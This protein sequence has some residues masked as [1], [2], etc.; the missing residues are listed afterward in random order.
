M[1]RVEFIT[2][3]SKR[4]LLIDF[5]NLKVEEVL[6]VIA[7][8]KKVMEQQPK[9]SVITLTDLTH[10]S[11]NPEVA[12]A[13][14]EYTV[15]NKPYVKVAAVVGATGLMGVVK[16]GVEKTSMRDLVNFATRE[17]AQ[18]WLIGQN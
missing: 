5:S 18:E 8:A 13:M 10:M 12:S 4:I 9:G 16:D 14:K 2:Y 11:F 7:E 3:K 6:P 15:H 17:Q 1:K